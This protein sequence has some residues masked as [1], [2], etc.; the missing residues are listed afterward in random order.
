MLPIII[1]KKSQQVSLAVPEGKYSISSHTSVS[2]R[3]A[4][5][6]LIITCFWLLPIRDTS[7]CI[8]PTRNRRTF[9]HSV[10]HIIIALLCMPYNPPVLYFVA[11]TK[12][13]C[14]YLRRIKMYWNKHQTGCHS[15]ADLLQR[16][17]GHLSIADCFIRVTN[18]YLWVKAYAHT[19]SICSIMTK[20][21]H[22][23]CCTIQL[24]LLHNLVNPAT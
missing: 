11:F 16:L 5:L 13:M 7:L 20:Y 1:W 22:K 3:P 19:V 8:G 12:K 15:L 18:W 14:F 4:G 2:E 10:F 9:F 24:F 17:N 6:G 23:M 21:C